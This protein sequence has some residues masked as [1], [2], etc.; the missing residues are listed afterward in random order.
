MGVAGRRVSERVEDEQLLGRVGE[1]VVAAHHL[2]DPHLGV[3]DGD[4]E[5]VEDRAVAAGDHE[6]VVAG[7]G[8]GD[9]AADQVLDHGLALVGD[10]QPDRR[11][12]LLARRCRGSRARR[13]ARPSRPRRPWRSPRRGRRRRTRAAAPARPRGAR[14]ARPGRSGPS[15]QSSSSQRSAS[16]ICS[17]FSGGRALA[18]GVLDPQHQLAALVARREPV[19]ECRPRSAD[20]QRTGRR[21]GESETGV[22]AGHVDRSACFHR[23]GARQRDRARRRARLRIYPDLPPEPADVAADPLRRRGLRRLPRGDGRTPRSKRW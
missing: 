22:F 8:E 12:R 17:T 5:V 1:V 13:R 3:V 14:P 19:V 15:S 2:G 21:G 23:R 11:A 7:V 4:R 10:P 9:L 16:R 6:V 20:V 18:V